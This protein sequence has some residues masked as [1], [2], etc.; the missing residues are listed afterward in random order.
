MNSMWTTSFS[1]ST[2]LGLGAFT[3]G[4]IATAQAPYF[5]PAASRADSGTGRS[6]NTATA[7]AGR[8]ATTVAPHDAGPPAPAAPYTGGPR[9]ELLGY[10]PV[11]GVYAYVERMTTSAPGFIQ[12]TIVELTREGNAQRLR[13]TTDGD[14]SQYRATQNSP[15]TRSLIESR[16]QHD[17]DAARARFRPGTIV[18]VPQLYVGSGCLRPPYNRTD[19]TLGDGIHVLIQPSPDASTASVRLV[20]NNREGAAEEVISPM[21][22][23]GTT[24]LHV[25]FTR[26]ADAREIPGEDA[27]FLLLRSDACVPATSPVPARAVRLALPPPAERPLQALAHAELQEFAILRALVPRVRRRV[28]D[29]TPG[30]YEGSARIIFDNAWQLS[31]TGAD[32]RILVQYTRVEPDLSPVVVESGQ[33]LARFAVVS[34][35]GSGRFRVLSQLIPPMNENVFEGNGQEAFPVDIDGDGQTEIVMRT[36]YR[37]DN[38][39]ATVLRLQ[40]DMLQFA[41]RGNTGFDERRERPGLAA[42]VRRCTLGVDGR[43]LVVRCHVATYAPNAGPNAE[44]TARGRLVQR[45]ESRGGVFLLTEGNR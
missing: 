22:Y 38:S 9:E 18:P 34:R 2:A 13:L 25:P 5:A 32:E 15:T 39:L 33:A 30:F 24:T 12:Y 31:P 44:P 42:N 3:A 4:T 29:E 1:V 10:D 14:L 26:V 27:Y 40:G 7:D 35:N 20:E 21:I 6:A 41:W 17:I 8:A 37:P 11:R 23:T 45:L 36:V 19:Q 28:V 16:V 43:T